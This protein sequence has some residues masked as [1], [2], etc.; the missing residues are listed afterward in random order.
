MKIAISSTTGEP[1]QEFSARFGRCEYFAINDTD[2]GEW[3]LIPNPAQDVQGGSGTQVVQVLA[4]N[5]VNATISGRYGPHAF[6]ALSAAGMDAYLAFSGTPIELLQQYNDGILDLA[7]GPSGQGFHRQ[8]R[9][10]K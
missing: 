4:D 6:D 10:R 3:G 8:G 9:G 7:T 1:G 2:T 5:G